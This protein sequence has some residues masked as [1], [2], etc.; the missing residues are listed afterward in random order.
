MAFLLVAPPFIAASGFQTPGVSGLSS[1]QGANV[2]LYT[3]QF[4]FGIPLVQIPT[5]SFNYP[6]TLGY[7]SG[8]KMNQQA[9]WV[10]LGWDLSPGAITR[11]PRGMPDDWNDFRYYEWNEGGGLSG[12]LSMFGVSISFSPN[13]FNIAFSPIQFIMSLSGNPISIFQPGFSNIPT[14]LDSDTGGDLTQVFGFN[15]IQG[16]TMVL[17]NIMQENGL[18]RMPGPQQPNRV[19]DVVPDLY[20]VTSSL[21]LSGAMSPYRPSTSIECSR[22]CSTDIS[23]CDGCLN[24]GTC[25][26]NSAYYFLNMP[27]DLRKIEHGTHSDGSIKYFVITDVDGTRYIYSYQVYMKTSET[28]SRMSDGCATCNDLSI[29]RYPQY[30]Y[31]WLLSA[32]L[33]PNFDDKPP[34]VNY[35]GFTMGD[36]ERNIDGIDE[37]D[38]GDWVK[39]TYSIYQNNYDFE[40]PMEPGVW[41]SKRDDVSNKYLG[42]G[43]EYKYEITMLGVKE[44]VVLNRIDTPTHY[45]EFQ[46]SDRLDDS[47]WNGGNT[48]KYPK[49]LDSLKLYSKSDLGTP[50]K[51]IDFNYDYSLHFFSPNSIAPHPDWTLDD[52]GRLTLNSVTVYGANDEMSIPPY[53][54]KYYDYFYPSILPSV[55]KHQ[56]DPW[57]YFNKLAFDDYHYLNTQPWADPDGSGALQYEFDAHAW[58]LKNVHYPTGGELEIFYEPNSYRYIGDQPSQVCLQYTET[59][60]DCSLDYDSYG[61]G[62]RTQYLAYWDGTYSTR[63]SEQKIRYYYVNDDQGDETYDSSGVLTAMDLGYYGDRSFGFTPNGLAYKLG[64]NLYGHR[65]LGGNTMNFVGYQKVIEV[66]QWNDCVMPGCVDEPYGRIVHE[67]ATAKDSDLQNG[68]LDYNTDYGTI[69]T[70]YPSPQARYYGI[71]REWKRGVEKQTIY[72]N[73]DDEIVKIFSYGYERVLQLTYALNFVDSNNHD[74]PSTQLEWGYTKA[75]SMNVALDGQWSSIT[76][77]YNSEGLINK[78]TESNTNKDKISEI[79]YAYERPEYSE[80]RDWNILTPI[81]YTQTSEK[82]RNTN[83]ITLLSASKNTFSKFPAT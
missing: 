2:N 56:F 49:K 27:K 52:K 60:Y 58:S 25:L 55:H 43:S 80:M 74:Y 13:G 33:A 32:V 63:G 7:A 8:I 77:D 5:R 50:I 81:Y 20:S 40:E 45:V 6:L 12:G 36:S 65:Y 37:N 54:F 75:T 51:T 57:G 71:D 79:T 82:D 26:G 23:T 29:N 1:G 41:R 15:Y 42:D 14:G 61:Y 53:T 31:A 83:V 16:Q 70:N 19:L 78:I 66:P 62:I 46:T 34:Y 17:E 30:A 73:A 35:R 44:L 22:E 47:S 48:N 38:A 69:I 76:Y 11:M 3:G 59:S 64:P 39:F 10:G 21:G 18:C 9:S 68:F 28:E 24:R 4:T 72:Y 67:F